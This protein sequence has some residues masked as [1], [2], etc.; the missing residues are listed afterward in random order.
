MNVWVVVAKWKRWAQNAAG[1]PLLY[2]V[3]APPDHGLKTFLV[4]NSKSF[5]FEP[6]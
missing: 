2:G 6:L 5:L 3:V 1:H 4:L